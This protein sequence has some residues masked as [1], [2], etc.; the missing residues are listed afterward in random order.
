MKLAIAGAIAAG[1][2]NG[3]AVFTVDSNLGAALAAL[4]STVVVTMSV[5]SWIDRRIDGKI[6]PVLE[7]LKTIKGVLIDRRQAESH[8]HAKTES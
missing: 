7:E 1:L 5:I 6:A 4:A 3:A 8:G 2:L